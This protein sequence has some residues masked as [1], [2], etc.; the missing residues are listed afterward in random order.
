MANWLNQLQSLLGQQ[1]PSSSSGERSDGKASFCPGAGRP[2]GLLVASKSSRKLL[3]K[4][5]TS[6][7]LVGGGAVAEACC[8]TSTSKKCGKFPAQSV[9]SPVQ[10]AGRQPRQPPGSMP[11]VNGSFWRWCLPR[12]ATGTLMTASGQT[13]MSSCARLVL[14]CRARS[15]RSRSGP[16][17]RS[18]RLA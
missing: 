8:G 14:P 17:S 4:Y 2:G 9:A 6:A 16:A 5:G 15:Y 3:A 18:A 1:G 10:P 11:A 13:L 7:L 12:K